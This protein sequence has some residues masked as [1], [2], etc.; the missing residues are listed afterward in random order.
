MT[1]VWVV[2][3]YYSPDSVARRISR[4]RAMLLGGQ[5]ALL[6]QIAHPLVAAGVAGHSSFAADPLAR[7]RRTLDSTLAIVFG[8]RAQADAAVAK[9]NNVHAYVHGELPEA[10][11][12]FVAR[13][14][15]D[16][17]DPELLLW[18]HATLIDTSMT[19]YPRFV[20]SLSERDLDRAYD[21]SKTVAVLLGVPRD[22]LPDDLE[23]FRA[24]F[25]RMISSDAIAVAPFQRALA[26]DILHPSLRFVPR[27]AYW[28]SVA[29]TAALL[30]ARVRELYGL[31]EPSRRFVNW[32]ER[33]VRGMLPFVPGV[34][35]YMP[36]ARRADRRGT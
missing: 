16:A 12:R 32:S 27:S 35:R 2:D 24:Y 26:D 31:Q 9:I 4:E 29:L 7:L 22:I 3:G 18:V 28:P 8:T 25:A 13:T 20:R 5:R 14:A 17:L 34:L 19:V 1:I 15:Y 11:G 33:L 6:L 10:A 36:Q 23:A 30:P 21:E